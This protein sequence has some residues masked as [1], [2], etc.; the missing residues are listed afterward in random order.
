MP[1]AGR[2]L[3]RDDDSKDMRAEEVMR[4]APVDG[5]AP[6]QHH[7]EARLRGRHIERGCCEDCDRPCLVGAKGFEDADPVGVDQCVGRRQLGGSDL[8]GLQARHVEVVVLAEHRSGLEAGRS[9]GPRPARGRRVLRRDLDVLVCLG[10]VLRPCEREEP[11]DKHDGYTDQHGRQQVAGDEAH[12]A[13]IGKRWRL[14]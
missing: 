11:C 7:R 6:A 4:A 12:A 13:T 8:D 9:L 14:L 1:G 2:E 3:G 10:V 5:C